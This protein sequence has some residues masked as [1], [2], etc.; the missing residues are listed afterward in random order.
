MSQTIRRLL[1]LAAPFTREIA[2]AVLLGMATVASGVGLMATSAYI[3][4]RAALHPSI[5]VLEVAI[6]GVRFFGIAR[7]VFRYLERYV[8]HDITFRLLARVRVWFYERL[9]PLAPARLLSY[10]SGDLLTRVV[11]DVETLQHFYVRVIAPPAVAVLTTLGMWIF[12]AAFDLRLA[13]T[14]LV[15]VLL[16]GVGVPL[17]ARRLTRGLGERLIAVRAELH[18]QAV[19][20][21]QGMAELVVFGQERAHQRQLAVLSR[22]FTRLNQRLAWL[23]SLQ[24][25]LVSLLATLAGLAVLLV[26]I[27]LVTAGR[28]D[29]VFL[30]V[31]ALAATAMFEAIAPLPAV[32][33]QAETSAAAADRLFEIVDAVPAVRAPTA[34]LP[35]PRDTRLAVEGLRFRY[36][37]D[38]PLA[39]DGVSFTLEPGQT[40]AIVGPSGAGKSTLVSLLLRFWD[41]DDGRITLGGR[42]LRAYDPEEVRRQVSVVAQ[43]PALFN[44]TIRQNLLLARPDAT[45]AE[46]RE[47]VR[48]AH[49]DGVIE[50]LPNG[51]D[52]WIGEGGA[53]L[54]GGERQR[55]AIARALLKDARLL[56][57]DEATANLD[58]VTEREL[59]RDLEML[60]AGRTTLV[61][62]HRL[63]GL[64]RASEI[65]VLRGGRIIERGSQADLLAQESLYRHMWELQHR[66]LLAAPDEAE[67][68]AGASQPAAAPVG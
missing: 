14:L 52:T 61:I 65:L 64:E 4:S 62:T 35:A 7:G 23:T 68:V 39:L 21:I 30:A 13:N 31:L 36:G 58:P 42:D 44:A 57:L 20:G 28:L 59:L 26:A 43:Q 9:E 5:A 66:A 55:L 11:G 32:F 12:M 63:A 51:Y 29:G 27:P 34:P 54:S 25:A 1:A 19:D 18:A 47:A 2:L 49:L 3:I 45:E 15:F 53:R 10:R 67:P 40:L 41:Y 22:R 56:I 48:Q 38:E 6:V 24:A 17:L 50:R 46:L 60:T 16:A 37:P 8:S 33:Q